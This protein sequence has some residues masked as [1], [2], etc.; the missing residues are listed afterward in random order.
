M[1]KTFVPLT[2]AFLLIASITYAGDE[3]E[4]IAATMDKEIASYLNKDYDAWADCWVHEPYVTLSFARDGYAEFTKSWESLSSDVKKD[5]ESNQD[6]NFNIVKG[7]YDI[8][9]FGETAFVTSKEKVS[10]DLFGKTREY[11]Q[12]SSNMLKKEGGK[13]KFV[14]MSIIND[15]S[16]EVNDFNT[17]MQLNLTGYKLLG[18]D[19]VDRA[20]EVFELNTRLFPESYNT[21]D[22]L[23]EGYM[24]K[25]DKEKAV[26]YYQKS[27][28][29]NPENTNAKNMIKK[30]NNEG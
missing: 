21:W 19:Q 10:L 25:G 1:K 24:K 26:K 13:W 12:V 23:A 9:V 15:G 2:V 8:Q 29:L 22:S 30:M 27:I 4:A 28:T 6:D 17:E 11:S 16:Y 5:M 14:S 7:D 20:I 3:K 18:K